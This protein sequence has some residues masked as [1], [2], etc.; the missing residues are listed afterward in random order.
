MNEILKAR[1][2]ERMEALDM[3]PS[4]VALEAGL[5]RSAVRDILSGKAKNPGMM[6][7]HAIAR[8]L[9]CSDNYLM[10]FSDEKHYAEATDILIDVLAR[11]GDSS[12][13]LEA[14]V[15]RQY[16]GWGDTFPGNDPFES[17]PP[18]VR[19]RERR[20]MNSPRRYIGRDLYLYIMGDNS[21]D[22]LSILKDDILIAFHDA[23]GEG[24][25]FQEGKIFV[26]S[27]RVEGLD[28]IELS[29]RVVR[30]RDGK[31]VLTTASSHAL[32]APIIVSEKGDKPNTYRT[33]AGGMIEVE[34]IVAEI[35]RQLDV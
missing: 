8:V 29:A 17:D 24:M 33:S 28:A 12:G 34:G 19:R 10:G 14:G 20:P 16:I 1:I 22:E 30:K 21:L 25:H 11:R 15:F 35:T 5:S 31:P 2:R 3:N 27:H 6:T 26:V 18:H 9:K 7:V 32:L 4:S 23:S 13:T